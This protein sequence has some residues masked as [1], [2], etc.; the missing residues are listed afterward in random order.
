MAAG[1]FLCTFLLAADSKPILGR[2]VLHGQSQPVDQPIR[3]SQT[4][5]SALKFVLTLLLSAMWTHR[6]RP[7]FPK[8]RHLNPPMLRVAE[9]EFRS[10][11]TGDI[12]CWSDSP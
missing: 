11:D 7:V 12:V 2:Y 6:S 4:T 9:A 8:P 10:L 5:A 1:L 3:A